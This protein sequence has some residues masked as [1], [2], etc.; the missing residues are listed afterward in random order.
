MDK[1]T[2]HMTH[3]KNSQFMPINV[4]LVTLELFWDLLHPV[5]LLSQFLNAVGLLA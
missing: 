1:V 4:H 2:F 5:P 3:N